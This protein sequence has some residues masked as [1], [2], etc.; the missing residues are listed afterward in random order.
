MAW[1]ADAMSS[2]R[3]KQNSGDLKQYYK[4]YG[5]LG[6]LAATMS[7][8]KIAINSSG[9]SLSDSIYVLFIYYEDFTKVL[10]G[11]MEPVVSSIGRYMFQYLDMEFH[12]FPHWRDIFVILSILMGANIKA[13]E[14]E[15][16]LSSVVILSVLAFIISISTAILAGGVPLSETLGS[17]NNFSDFMLGVTDMGLLPARL[18][19][20]LLGTLIPI[21]DSFYPPDSEYIPVDCMIILCA[22]SVF[23]SISLSIISANFGDS[24][25][26]NWKL[27]F[28]PWMIFVSISISFGFVYWLFGIVIQAFGKSTGEISQMGIYLVFTILVF[29]AVAQIIFGLYNPSNA[30]LGHNFLDRSHG[31]NNFNV[32]YSGKIREISINSGKYIA[33]TIFGAFLFILSNAGLSLLGL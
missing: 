10:L 8:A 3:Y 25:I 7:M 9:Q 22:L 11:W 16:K 24:K 21:P 23:A 12:I 2:N 5:I 17:R 13:M 14:K 15:I 18:V 20:A 31:G 33:G 28:S 32:S 26:L 19:M 29:S 6:A 1:E 30:N 4:I 27:I